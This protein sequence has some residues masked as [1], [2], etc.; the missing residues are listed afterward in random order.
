MWYELKGLFTDPKTLP[1]VIFVGVCVVC[2][3]GAFVKMIFDINNDKK[4]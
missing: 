4:K 3:I 2:I 1:L